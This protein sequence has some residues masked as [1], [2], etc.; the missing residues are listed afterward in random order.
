MMLGARLASSVC[1]PL[2]WLDLKASAGIGLMVWMLLPGMRFLA[3]AVSQDVFHLLKKPST[4]DCQIL[5]TFPSHDLGGELEQRS[6]ETVHWESFVQTNGSTD[7]FATGVRQLMSM[8][9]EVEKARGCEDARAKSEV[10]V[11][12]QKFIKS[13]KEDGR[14]A[15]DEDGD[16]EAHL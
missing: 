6:L 13:P 4:L 11:M 7:S 16:V 10:M 3:A 9:D 12:V 2:L 1:L 5:I 8:L 14:G 15:K